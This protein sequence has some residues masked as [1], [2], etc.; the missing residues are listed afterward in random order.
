MPGDFTSHDS[1]VQVVV[2]GPLEI[3][4]R[5]IKTVISELESDDKKGLTTEEANKRF[6]RDGPNELE[7]PPRISLFML[8]IVQLNSV[9][10][11]LLL[12]AVVASAV[13]KATGDD[14]DKFIS[15]VDS[16]AILIIVFINATIAAVTE[17]NANDALEALSNLQSPKCTVIRS[18]KDETIESKEL[19]VGDIVKLATGDVVPADIRCIT[20][21]DFRVNEMLLTG[22]PE[23]VAKNSA[24]KERKEGE[25]V[26]LMPDNMAFSSSNVKSGEA[27]CIVVETGMQT[28]VGA[29][30][31]L[32]NGD[33]EEEVEEETAAENADGTA[34]GTLAPKKKK[35]KSKPCLPDTKAG[36]SPLQANLEKLA[37][38]LGYMAIGVCMIVFVVG[39]LLD[40]KDPE[41]PDPPSW[42][43]M[44][45]VAV[46]LTVAAI[47]EGLPLCVTIA[48]SEGCNQMVEEN[49]L[50]RKIAAIETL[51]SASIICTDKTGTLTEGKMTLV[52]MYS[53]STD[54]AVTGKGFDPTVGDIT[55]GTTPGTNT[56][57][58]NSKEAASVLA[59]LGS[60]VLCSNTTLELVE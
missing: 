44:I 10:M 16:I 40:T 5:D 24:V 27:L 26:K 51:G 9:I 46:T 48:L 20:A 8:F 58:D 31:A 28:R 18:G 23:D 54:Y 32:L 49:V 47:P 50:M 53:G 7:T 14:K 17:N 41:E 2:R 19:V 21:D 45:L 29:I 33:D 55:V 22:E 60:A 56:G 35:K 11:Y 57:G 3:H 34:D 59:T 30:A 25:E 4:E 52:A 12:A 43:F 38:K 39:V 37:V 6:L 15:Y 1:K 36:Q 13:I 42:L